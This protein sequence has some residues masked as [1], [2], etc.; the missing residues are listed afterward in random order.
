MR[1]GTELLLGCHERNGCNKCGDIGSREVVPATGN[2]LKM[3]RH[4]IV[5][6]YTSVFQ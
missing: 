6:P 4:M 2:L 5:E 1:L 3:L